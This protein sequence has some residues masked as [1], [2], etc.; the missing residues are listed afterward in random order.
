MASGEWDLKE[1]TVKRNVRFYSCCPDEPFPDVMFYIHIRRRI[2]YYLVNIMI[3]CIFLSMISV[4]TFWLPPDSGEKIALSITV[5]LAY[6]VFMLLI[7]ENIPATSE[8]V[9]LIGIYLTFTMSLTFF[10]IVLTVFVLQLHHATHYAPRISRRVY[11]FIT[12]RMGKLVKCLF[13]FH[14]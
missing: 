3:P 10:S 6:S 8:M 5:L 11:D 12:I 9:P 7:A 14:I 2:L 1:I 4:M 13:Y